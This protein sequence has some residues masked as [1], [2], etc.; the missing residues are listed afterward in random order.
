MTTQ[1]FKTLVLDILQQSQLDGETFLQKLDKTERHARGTPEHWSA[2]DHLAHMTFWHQDLMLKIIAV[3]QQQELPSDEES[4]ELINA[5]VFE[6]HRQRPWSTIQVEYAQAF[7]RLIALTEHLTEQDLTTSDR[8]AT[9]SEGRPLYTAFL[10]SCYEHDHEHLA[11]YYLDRNTQELA[12][13]VREQCVSRIMQAELPDQ[14]KGSFLYNLACFYT[15]LQHLQKAAALLQEALTLAPHLIKH[16]Q[17]D[18]ELAALRP[19]SA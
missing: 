6:E 5:Q 1:P 13:E 16:A 10:G 12:I 11:H 3:L 18:P 2:R 17:N 19:Q 14:V 9:I 15:Q 4:E 8:F 7:A